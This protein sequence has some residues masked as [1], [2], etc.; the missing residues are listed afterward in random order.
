LTVFKKLPLSIEQQLQQWCNRGLLVSDP[1]QAKATL[2]SV[3][4]Y[5]LSAYTLP[6]Q[7]QSSEH[8]F[9]AGTSF[10]DV[11]TLYEFD[12]KLRRQILTAIEIIEVALRAS[13]TN[14][15]SEHHG[16]H[17][18]LNSQIF[19]S[20]YNHQWLINQIR[21]K[22]NDGRPE[23]FIKHYCNKYTSPELPPLWMIIELLTFKEI[24]VLFSHL[25]IKKDGSSAESVGN[26]CP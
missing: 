15:L 12:S 21:R 9:I 20:S 8:Q 1:L 22:C 16:S 23:V 3:S 18:Y 11:V 7:K 17:G 4:Y 5:R 24:S 25:R 19:H 26:L 10:M 13:M 14:I 6:F 2:S